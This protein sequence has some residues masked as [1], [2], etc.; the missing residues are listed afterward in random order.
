[1]EVDLNSDKRVVRMI[2]KNISKEGA[3]FSITD[4]DLAMRGDPYHELAILISS[5]KYDG[6]SSNG[7]A[8]I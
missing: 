2:L 4:F 6:P 1:V 7:H 3:R 8:R 5:L